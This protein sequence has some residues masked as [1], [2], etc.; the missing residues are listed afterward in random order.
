[1]GHPCGPPTLN[2]QPHLSDAMRARGAAAA[3]SAAGFAAGLTAAGAAGFAAGITAAARAAGFAAGFTAGRRAGGGGSAE[4]ADEDLPSDEAQDAGKE[5]NSGI[6]AHM[7]SHRV[8]QRAKP[9][10]R[11]ASLSVRIIASNLIPPP[12]SSSPASTRNHGAIRYARDPP[13]APAAAAA[14]A[15]AGA[16]APAVPAWQLFLNTQSPDQSGKCPKMR[17]LIAKQNYSHTLCVLPY[18][19][20]RSL[21]SARSTGTARGPATA[22]AA[23]WWGRSP[24]QRQ[25][26]A[27]ARAP[28]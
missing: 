22:R 17:I 21:P 18:N 16:A 11:V 23:R 9:F 2:T 25:R 7:R 4:V 20:H 28:L 8:P 12:V 27:L 10:K 14:A 6:P 26:R 15:A 1:M 5:R 19:L 3:G 13:A 24:A